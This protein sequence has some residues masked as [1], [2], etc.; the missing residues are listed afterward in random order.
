MKI[1]FVTY[2]MPLPRY[3]GSSQR[4]YLLIRA[5]SRHHQVDIFLLR[6]ENQADFL[7]N[8]GFNVVG[9][10]PLKERSGW[11][12]QLERLFSISAM[13]AALTQWS[14]LSFPEFFE[15]VDM[16]WWLIVI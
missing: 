13:S 4:T 3:A 16:I 11:K 7:R 10:S 14:M 8:A 5:L 9:Y 1:L 2:N 12:L 15:K 6:G